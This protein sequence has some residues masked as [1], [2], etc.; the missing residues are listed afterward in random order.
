MEDVR[1]TYC[2]GVETFLAGRVPNLIPQHTVL[3]TALLCE[4]S[5]SYRRLFVGLELIRDLC[6]KLWWTVGEQNTD[7]ARIAALLMTFQPPPRL[8]PWRHVSDEVEWETQRA[9]CRMDASGWTHDPDHIGGRVV[10]LRTSKGWQR[11]LHSP[12]ST[13]LT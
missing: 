1:G 4:E 2:K 7:Y 3:Q 5:G 11:R 8:W 6:G 12:R 9:E 13:S 10:E